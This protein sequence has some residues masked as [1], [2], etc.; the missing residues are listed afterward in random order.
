MSYFEFP[1]T[2]N[3]DGDLGYIIKKLEELNDAYNNFF[4]LN[5]ITF[6]DPIEWDISESYKANT[7]VYDVQSETL[8]ISRDAIPA[9]IDI[10]NTDYWNVVSPF[11][12]DTSF[13]TS[14][15]NPVANKIITNKINSMDDIIA[16]HTSN[17]NN[18]NGR[19]LTLET[20]LGEEIATREENE[21][22]INARIDN[23]IALEPGSTTGDA[24]LADI[25]VGA[26]G[27]T[28]ETAGD[29]VRG[30][31]LDLF[32]YSS[33]TNQLSLSFT[34][35]MIFSCQN[36]DFFSLPNTCYAVVPVEDCRGL[37]IDYAKVY[38]TNVP[39]VVYFSGTPDTDTF[40]S[41]DGAGN[42]TGGV[43]EI[44]NV[45]CSIPANCKYVIIQGYY[46][47][48]TNTGRP[49][50]TAN[51]GLKRYA[52]LQQESKSRIQYSLLGTD[53]SISSDYGNEK[54]TIVFGKRGPN[55]LPDFKSIVA[56]TRTLYNGGTDWCAPY[57]VGAVNNPNGD[58]PTNHTFT[59]GNHNYNNTGTLD[60]SATARNISLKFYAD[61][62]LLSSG[63]SGYCN[64]ISIV[65]VNQIQAYNTRK[66]DGTGREV[67]KETRFMS[68]DGSTM[69]S[70]VM[71][72]PLE[73]II[74]ETYYGYQAS[75]PSWNNILFINGTNHTP[76]AYT[77]HPESGNALPN[78]MYC[79]STTDLL[80]ISIDRTYD[81]GTGN[82]FS[83]DNGM[84]SSGNK[85]Y[86]NLIK[87]KTM[88]QHN[89]YSAIGAW[90]F[91]PV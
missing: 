47:S 57:I 25:R 46:T 16:S 14:S 7:I 1:H 6:H 91:K 42:P 19:T 72:D 78:E 37:V 27:E 88:G 77:D 52:Q 5:K 34:D 17:L 3:Y 85:Y 51:I 31:T 86:C 87:N 61:G 39:A 13:S 90:S 36:H 83:G 10:S 64:N 75:A 40:I 30:Q 44:T 29:A 22:V 62:K 63:D 26:W 15:I 38:R 33:T 23:I 69:T 65:F 11:K 48:A 54:L 58:D 20:D 71:I 28:Y 32:D 76:H 81:L 60:A 49:R 8:Y 45:V 53:L 79:Y 2:R 59:G 18:L 68:F 67:L 84:F 24:E 70:K 21:G 55:E 56:G 74:I 35:G 66:I 89:I 50:A 80:E 43:E 4:D 73:S 82:C 41:Y 12:I 9:G